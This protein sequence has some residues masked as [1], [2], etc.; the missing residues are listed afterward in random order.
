VNKYTVILGRP[1]AR[2]DVTE[3]M[4]AAIEKAVGT[5]GITGFTLF[6]VRNGWQM[7]VRPKDESGWKVS[8]VPEERALAIL[9]DMEKFVVGDV[10]KPKPEWAGNP[11]EVPSGRVRE[12]APWGN[13]GALYVGGEPRAFAASTFEHDRSFEASL[14]AAQEAVRALTTAIEAWTPA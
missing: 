8:I 6:A 13:E 9:S 4:M 12:V 1:P 11:N 10:V 14:E 7:S 3:K 5:D 2:I